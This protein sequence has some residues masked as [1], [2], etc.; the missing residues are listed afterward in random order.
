MVTSHGTDELFRYE[1]GWPFANEELGKDLVDAFEIEEWVEISPLRLRPGEALVAGWEEFSKQVRTVTR[2]L[3]FKEPEGY[4]DWV[5]PRRMLQEIH[6]LVDEYEL[7]VQMERNTFLF[8]ARHSWNLDEVYRSVED[9][10]APSPEKA[11][12]SSRMSPA[13]IPVFYGALD[14]DTAVAETLAHA[15][16]GGTTSRVRVSWGTFR[17]LDSMRLLDLTSMRPVPGF[18]ST[19]RRNREA[20]SFLGVFAKQVARPIP[21]DGR[22]HIEYAPTQVVA[23]YFRHAYEGPDG[24]R[25]DGILYPSSVSEGGTSCVLFLGAEHCC[26]L[27]EWD[28]TD[29]PHRLGLDGTSTGSSLL[30]DSMGTRFPGGETRA[31]QPLHSRP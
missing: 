12:T 10:G 20:L 8:R 4:E 2:Y 9:L 5:D 1:I 27:E 19:E 16:A 15:S 31:S 7:V 6:K 17:T 26:D 29:E 25:I 13:G 11:K 3:F 28:G 24:S 23:E 18:F 14:L 22:E 30:Q 21:Q